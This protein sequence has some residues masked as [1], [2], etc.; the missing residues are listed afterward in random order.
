[1]ENNSTYSANHAS[2]VT[3]SND[4]EGRVESNLIGHHLHAQSSLLHLSILVVLQSTMGYAKQIE[5]LPHGES[6][7]LDELL[8]IEVSNNSASVFDGELFHS[9]IITRVEVAGDLAHNRLSFQSFGLSS[10]VLQVNQWMGNPT[11]PWMF[12]TF[13]VILEPTK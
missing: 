5:I 2:I 6:G 8:D 3:L 13:I 1:M 11:M 7:L 12:F 9:A 4:I 10:Q